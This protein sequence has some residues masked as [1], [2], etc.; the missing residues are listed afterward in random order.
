MKFISTLF[1]A[2]A[3]ANLLMPQ[4]L[5]ADNA[6]ANFRVG[7]AE[8]S[9]PLPDGYC[10][11][12]GKDIDVAQLMAAADKVN[13]THAMVVKCGSQPQLLDYFIL[14]TPVEALLPVLDRQEFLKLMKTEFVKPEMQNYMSDDKLE[15][16][17]GR[18]YEKVLQQKIS[19]DAQIDFRGS[20][21]V[22]VYLGGYGLVTDIPQPYS[23]AVG[24]CM[25]TVEGKMLS[26]NI[27]APPADSA[28]VAK[29]MTRA[30]EIALSIMAAPKK[31]D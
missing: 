1:A 29:L 27:Y 7:G 20:D 21:D 14:K 25:T 16:E 22:C 31:G 10:M 5:A 23:I 28:D 8:L 9:M 19:M 18:S 17:V 12:S 15:Q 11:P 13:V 3:A 2:T 30:R 24:L 4:V 26:V 6:S